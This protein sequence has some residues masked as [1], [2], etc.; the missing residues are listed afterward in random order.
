MH[1]ARHTAINLISQIL[2]M[3][4]AL[5]TNI[6]VARALGP[7]GKGAFALLLLTSGLVVLFIN[8]GLSRAAIYYL[9]KQTDTL[10]VVTNTLF[11]LAL[12]IGS[13]TALV[14]IVLIPL[15]APILFAGIPFDLIA[16]VM[17]GTPFA[18]WVMYSGHIFAGIQDFWRYNGVNLL[19]WV[20]RL[21]WLVVAFL[22]GTITLRTTATALLASVIVPAAIGWY[23]LRKIN[24]PIRP[25]IHVELIQRYISYGWRANSMQLV[26]FFNL[27]LDQFLVSIFLG[28]AQVGIYSVAVTMAE[29]AGSLAEAVAMSLLARVSTLDRDAAIYLTGRTAR[30][31]L[32]TTIVACGVMLL[33]GNFII[34]ILFGNDYASSVSALVLLLPGVMAIS[35]SKVLINHLAGTGRPE[36]GLYASL[37]GLVCTLIGDFTLIPILGIAGAALT[38]SVAYIAGGLVVTWAYLRDSKQHI[39]NILWITRE[40]IIAVRAL[41]SRMSV[42]LR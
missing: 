13:L 12:I 26:T 10:K 8:F 41:L 9:G 1:L 7:E 15:Y 31:T 30:I 3:L 25:Q 32:T 40:D 34:L 33:I 2:V 37:I 11:A 16:V 23:W 21:N 14:L 42:S 29:L 20:V 17:A 38:S 24:G 4:M 39:R 35:L 18:L 27:R 22:L 28:L 19:T 6:I 5:S 36:I